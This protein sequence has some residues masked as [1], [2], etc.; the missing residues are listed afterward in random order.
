[1]CNLARQTSLD[2]VKEINN[3]T[4]A[5]MREHGLG[6]WLFKEAPLEIDAFECFAEAR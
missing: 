6:G 1:M 4:L 3:L 5:M 2:I